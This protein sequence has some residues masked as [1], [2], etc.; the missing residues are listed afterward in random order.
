MTTQRLKIALMVGA[1]EHGGA[2]RQLIA[3]AKG[4][5][6]EGHDVQVWCYTNASDQDEYVRSLG[7]TVRTGTPA[8][9][10][11]KKRMVRGW[12][13]DWKPSVVHC[14]MKRASVLGVLAR[15]WRR[16]PAIIAS[17]YSTAAYGKRDHVLWSSLAAFRLADRVLTETGYN[18]ACLERLAPWLK[19]RVEVVR[20]GV[21]VSHIF[22]KQ[23]QN[24]SRTFRF[25]VV[26]SVYKLKN[27][28]RLVQAVERLARQGL[29]FTIDW[30]GRKGLAGDDHPSA[31]FQDCTDLI[32]TYDLQSYIRF[33]GQSSEIERH[34]ANADALVH[35]SIQE[36]MPNAVVEAMAAGLPLVVS[37]VSDLPL[38]VAKANN[39]FIVDQKSPNS[40][41][42]GLHK[43]METP[44]TQRSLMGERSAALAR[45]WFGIETFTASHTAIY[46]KLVALRDQP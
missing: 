41:A 27:P 18:K 7:I 16:S 4:L 36:G 45:K 33:H 8:G 31:E 13:K 15:G 43:M 35:I 19:G 3:L 46:T 22:P 5:T 10:R 39:G 9:F 25:L 17:D 32:T 28:V 34:Y 14:F 20:N 2:E 40:I 26:G 44:D 37:N 38:I 1:L 6:D 23:T 30:Y 24:T 12:I 42:E 11:E 21:D 29:D